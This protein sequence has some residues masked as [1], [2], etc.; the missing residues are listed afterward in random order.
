M[1]ATRHDPARRVQV[2]AKAE[3][4]A[5]VFGDDSVI[6]LDGSSITMDCPLPDLTA[7]LVLRSLGLE[8]A[9]RHD[10]SFDP[11]PDGP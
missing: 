9:A 1:G 2:D 3:R 6:S 7:E 11:G 4:A 8:V 5:I 10:A